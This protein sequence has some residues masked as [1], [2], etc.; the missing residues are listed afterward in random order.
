MIWHP[1]ETNDTFLFFPVRL[2]CRSLGCFSGC[3]AEASTESTENE[4]LTH[5]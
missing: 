1:L 2:N 3:G 5:L 4:G